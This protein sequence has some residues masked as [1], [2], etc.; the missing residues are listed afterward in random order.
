MN[1]VSQLYIYFIYSTLKQC[2]ES[3]KMLCCQHR[4]SIHTQILKK[5]YNSCDVAYIHL[6]HLS[7]LIF[8]RFMVRP[9]CHQMIPSGF[10]QLESPQSC[11]FWGGT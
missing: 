1:D 5:C 9:L 2:H 3:A 4:T 7:N 11:C 10:I 6:F 8:S